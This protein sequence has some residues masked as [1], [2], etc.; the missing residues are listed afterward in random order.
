MK[1]PEKTVF[2]TILLIATLF[3]LFLLRWPEPPAACMHQP[4]AFNE[5]DADADG[6]VSEEF[7]AFHAKRRRHGRGRSR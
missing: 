3:A 4:P 2:E 7:T 1:S 6:F 5:V